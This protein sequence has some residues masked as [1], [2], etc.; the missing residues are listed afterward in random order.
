MSRII[1]WNTG[2]CPRKPPA[3]VPVPVWLKRDATRVLNR[4]IAQTALAPYCH[5]GPRGVGALAP[6]SRL[7]SN[8]FFCIGVIHVLWLDLLTHSEGSPILAR[9]GCFTVLLIVSVRFRSRQPE[10]PVPA[11]S[12]FCQPRCDK[13]RLLFIKSH[14]PSETAFLSLFISTYEAY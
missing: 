2:T 4:A 11:H 8:C 14:F 3:F 1:T 12:V 9:L 7:Q 10:P 6:L 5:S 13:N